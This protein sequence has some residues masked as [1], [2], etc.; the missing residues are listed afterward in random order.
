MKPV[1]VRHL[2]VA[3]QPHSSAPLPA[4]TL[5]F[6][7]LYPSTRWQGRAETMLDAMERH[8]PGGFMDRLFALMCARRASDLFVAV[9]RRTR[10]RHREG[11]PR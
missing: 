5:K 10:D 9:P 8:L 1:V 4:L 2:P 7:T 11:V 6:E 3:E